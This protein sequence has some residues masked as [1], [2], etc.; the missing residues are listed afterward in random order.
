MA[1]ECLFGVATLKDGIGNVG[2][3]RVW[4]ADGRF[5]A[6][7]S[8]DPLRRSIDILVLSDAAASGTL[9]LDVPL[10][11]QGAFG[12]M[13]ITP[14]PGGRIATTAVPQFVPEFAAG[15]PCR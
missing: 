7:G 1:L 10:R 15:N 3:V 13:T 4:A 6:S 12:Q 8:F 2:P 11:L 5:L 14:V 9:A